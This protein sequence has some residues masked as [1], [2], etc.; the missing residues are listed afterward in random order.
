M[1]IVKVTL[2]HL[3]TVPSIFQMDETIKEKTQ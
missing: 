2:Q 3:Q 1:A